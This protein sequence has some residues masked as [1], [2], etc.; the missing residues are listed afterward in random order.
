LGGNNSIDDVEKIAQVK[1]LFEATSAQTAARDLIQHHSDL[2]D[3]ELQ[4]LN[5]DEDQKSRFRD[6]K[7]WLMH[8]TY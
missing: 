8:R 7:D 3:I 4:R 5:I 2:A 6:L 1:S